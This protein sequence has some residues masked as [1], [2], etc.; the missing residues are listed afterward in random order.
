[1]AI[2]SRSD[3]TSQAKWERWSMSTR[4]I[5]RCLLIVNTVVVIASAGCQTMTNRMARVA[6]P[7]AG[8]TEQSTPTGMAKT[9]FHREISRD[10]Q[11][12]VHVELAKV[13][14]S[15]GNNDAA[16]A[17]YDQAIA[18]GERR[19]SIL[20]SGKLGPEALSLAHRRMAAT[21]D[22]MGR[23]V[24]AETHYGQA[25]KLTPNDPKVWNDAGYSYYLQNRLPDAERALKTAKT[26]APNDA[27]ILTNLGLTQAMAGKTDEALA[28]L[29]QASGPAIGHANLG[30]ILAASGRDAEARKQYEIALAMQPEL[31][32]ARQAL[33][34]LDNHPTETAIARRDD[35]G[36]GINN[37]SERVD[38]NVAA[39]SIPSTNRP[40]D[41]P[42][43]TQSPAVGGPVERPAAEPPSPA[44]LLP[45]SPMPLSTRGM[46]QEAMPGPRIDP[47]TTGPSIGNAS[48]TTS[49]ETSIKGPATS[50]IEPAPAGDAI[51]PQPRTDRQSQ[52]VEPDTNS[53]ASAPDYAPPPSQ[54]AA[55]ANEAQD[56]IIP[57]TVVGENDSASAPDTSPS[58]LQAEAVPRSEPL[59][60]DAPQV[61]ASNPS[62]DVSTDSKALTPTPEPVPILA[63]EAAPPPATVAAPVRSEDPPQTP[64]PADLQSPFPP[65]MNELLTTPPKASQAMRADQAPGVNPSKTEPGQPPALVISPSKVE[66]APGSWMTLQPDPLPNTNPVSPYSSR[67]LELTSK[68]LP[69]AIALATG[70]SDS[71][72]GMIPPGVIEPSTLV[73][74]KS[75]PGELLANSAR[76]SR[77]QPTLPSKTTPAGTVPGWAV[78][79]NYRTAAYPPAPSDAA[80]RAPR[81]SAP[82]VAASNTIPATPW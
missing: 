66:P 32:P 64:I 78:P 59:A 41:A 36:R 50:W 80:T 73:P 25:L 39:T 5:R 24:L 4:T 6:P 57:L 31:G 77:T 49:I 23:F 27:R 1:M 56:T 37:S 29:G 44:S 13:H 30:F 28:T 34:K 63:T 48:R 14:E 65:G 76:P 47:A 10:Q 12:N 61:L 16:L 43:A 71:P 33:S 18:I 8:A 11:F 58:G 45:N 22:R 62:A 82:P 81:K 2:Q 74:T 40:A 79:K 75:Q 15:Q 7:Q 20:A 19:G 70:L 17:E 42:S 69:A 21:Y 38:P 72:S 46:S 53:A 35:Q 26:F 3:R 54:P 9:D 52:P 55:E 51:T 67:S 68:N 60:E